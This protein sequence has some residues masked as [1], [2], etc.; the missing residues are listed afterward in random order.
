MNTSTTIAIA[1]TLAAAQVAQKPAEP[2]LGQGAERYTWVHDWLKLPDG[3]QLGNTHGCVT[4]DSKGRILFNTDT[5]NAVIVVAPDGKF[6]KSWGKDFAGGLHGMTLVKEGDRELLWLAHTGRHEA[7]KTTLDGEVLMSIPYPA[8]S[9]VYKSA[10]EYLPTSVAVAPDGSIF[11]AD[12]YGKSYVHKYDAKGTWQK[13]FGGPGTEP[14][15]MQTPHGLLMDL[16]GSKPQLVVAD[17][18]NH[19]LQIFD[20]DCKLVSVV[21]KEL[22]LPCNVD[23]RGDEL[24]VADL[25]GRVTVLG[26]DNQLVCHLGDQPDESLRAQNGVPREKWQDGVFLSPHCAHWDADGNAYVLDWNSLG[27]I[28]KLQRVK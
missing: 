14:G 24:L 19:R 11:V 22:R 5:E 4:V 23:R 1:L 9:G 16:R 28:S 13:T 15:K 8:M 25:A 18:A 17:R 20:L 6:V 2:V 7:V 26:K 21:D 27:R 12:G 10:D 3:M